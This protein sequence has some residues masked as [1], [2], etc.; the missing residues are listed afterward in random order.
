MVDAR[1]V[2]VVLGTGR[3]QTPI[4]VRSAISRSWAQQASG[5]MS[6]VT[7]GETTDFLLRRA[8]GEDRDFRLHGDLSPG[9]VMDDPSST[10]L[11]RLDQTASD[12]IRTESATIDAAAE[13]VQGGDA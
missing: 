11:D 4:P 5:M 2:L 13:M 3:Q 8:L 6:M 7:E 12:L 9:I 1:S 10:N